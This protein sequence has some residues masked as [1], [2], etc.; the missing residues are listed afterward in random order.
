MKALAYVVEHDSGIF[1]PRQSETNVINISVSRHA[2][3]S[4]GIADIAEVVQLGF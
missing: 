2:A 3:T 1:I 4:A